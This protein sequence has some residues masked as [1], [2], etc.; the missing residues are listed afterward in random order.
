MFTAHH[1]YVNG[2][3]ITTEE[4]GEA[5]IIMLLVVATQSEVS[6]LLV[7]IPS[8]LFYAH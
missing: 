6:V 2:C 1:C 3:V 7:S 5:I 4:Q 8:F